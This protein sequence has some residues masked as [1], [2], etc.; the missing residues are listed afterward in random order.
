M[1][2]K[3]QSIVSY[4]LCISL[5]VIMIITPVVETS[6][7]YAEPNYISTPPD[8]MGNEALISNNKRLNNTN[9]ATTVGDMTDA[10][11]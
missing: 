8:D 6:A 2:S 1:R 4:I 10:Q 5:A 9:V 11:W 3:V 7:V